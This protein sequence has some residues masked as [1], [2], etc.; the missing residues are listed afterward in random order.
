MTK[1]ECLVLSQGWLGFAALTVE[2]GV[3]NRR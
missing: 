2:I 1:L 3:F